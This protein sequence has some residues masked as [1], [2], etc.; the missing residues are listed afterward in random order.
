MD[1]MKQYTCKHRENIYGYSTTITTDVIELRLDG[2]IIGEVNHPAKYTV[3]SLLV[4]KPDY[5]IFVSHKK[6]TPCVTGL[7][8]PL[9]VGLIN[10]D[11]PT[12]QVANHRNW[13]PSGISTCED[14]FQI[15]VEPKPKVLT[16][17]TCIIDQRDITRAIQWAELN[18]EKIMLIYWMFSNDIFECVDDTNRVFNF[19]KIMSSMKTVKRKPKYRKNKE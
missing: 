12:I 18:Y 4:D 6:L 3:T 8:Y 10:G 1:Y 13:I 9:Y 11:Y 16:P 19:V 2:C 7:R 17:N 15:S 5:A 14:S